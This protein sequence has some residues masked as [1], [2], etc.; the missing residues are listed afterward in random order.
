M[1]PV[2]VTKCCEDGKYVFLEALKKKFR[3]IGSCVITSALLQGTD[4]VS[5]DALLCIAE[6][7]I[8]VVHHPK[9]EIAVCFVL[10]KAC[11]YIHLHIFFCGISRQI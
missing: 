7:I 3:C 4:D 2:P 1:T 9:F 5:R 10:F 11:P 8:L 6:L